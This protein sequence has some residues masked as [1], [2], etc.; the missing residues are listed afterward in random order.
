ME[1]GPVCTWD[2]WNIN[3]RAL[4]ISQSA[5][6]GDMG[7]IFAPFFLDRLSLA[8]AGQGEKHVQ[9][10]QEEMWS[11]G[12]IRSLTSQGISVQLKCKPCR[13]VGAGASE[14]QESV[15]A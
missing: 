5:W 14:A 6:G 4:F 13:S 8:R 10:A 12:P 9:E 11:F 15:R 7:Q 1:S 2:V 3:E